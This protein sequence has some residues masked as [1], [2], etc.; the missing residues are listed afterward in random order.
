MTKRSIAMLLLLAMTLPFTGC[1]VRTVQHLTPAE[2]PHPE[3]EQI[4][5][6]TTAKGEDVKFDPPGA[7][8]KGDTLHATVNKAQFQIPLSQ[9]QRFW[10]MRQEVS[11][12]RTIGLVA[13]VTV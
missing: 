9:V 2:V 13:A 8:A 12:A 11:K 3:I 7:S 4:V 6:I 5:G 10:V 1:K